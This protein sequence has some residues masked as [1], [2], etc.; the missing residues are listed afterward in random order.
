MKWK[1]V[2]A[3][4]LLGAVA[5]VVLAALG[6]AG[7][8][9]YD[10]VNPAQVATDFTNT[11]FQGPDGITLNAYLAR[12]TAPGP[13]PAV[14]LIHE[15]YGINEDIIR[16]ADLLAE[17]G[18]TVLAV[19]A[20]RGKTTRLVP[21]AI[22]LVL[23]TPQDQITADMRSAAEY[24]SSL[25]GVD[26]ERVG[27]VG[28]CFGGTQVMQLGAVYPGLRASVIFYGSGL[29]TDPAMLGSLGQNGPV[30]GIFGEED[31]SIPLEE[32]RGFGAAMDTRGITST[33]TVYPGVGHAFVSTESI[34]SPGPARQAW[35][36]MLDFLA[37][38][39]K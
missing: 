1:Q 38:Q 2:A 9:A 12:Q 6:V 30:L 37:T 20:Y 36:E 4:V 7:V 5:L 29:I 34:R 18:Y 23:T 22:F 31:G 8:I 15:F 33:I 24:L 25:E 21:R 32:V 14:L 13:H 27:A 35:D 17:Q 3:R 10:T 16:K 11:T 26:P 39:L 28:F 19:D